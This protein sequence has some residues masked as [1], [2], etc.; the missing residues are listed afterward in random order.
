MVRRDQVHTA[1]GLTVL[2]FTHRQVAHEPD[3][4]THLLRQLRGGV[5]TP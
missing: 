4:V 5:P 2:R 1:A 3:A